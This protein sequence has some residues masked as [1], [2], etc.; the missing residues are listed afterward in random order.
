MQI[1]ALIRK[2]KYNP[3]LCKNLKIYNIT[4][5][6]RALQHSAFLVNL[7]NQGTVAISRWVSAKR[8]RSYPYARVYDTLAHTPRITIIPV[9][10]DEGIDGE[11]DYLQYDTVAMMS[12]LNV[13]V[14]IAY[15]D[16]AV[17]SNKMIGKQKISNQKVNL[18]FLREKILEK[19]NFQSDPLH[20]NLSQLEEVGK[21][22]EKAIQA[23]ERISR[24]TGVT[25]HSFGAAK[26]RIEEISKSTEDFKSISRKN[27]TMAANR[28]ILTS[29]LAES[30]T[31]NKPTIT[32]TNYVGG[33]YHL[34]V[35]EVHIDEKKN[36][37]NL[38]EAKNTTSP[39]KLITSESDIKDA[40]FK[41]IIFTN[42]EEVRVD[43]DL[44][45]HKSSVKF[46]SDKG[47]LFDKLSE[48]GKVEYK[49]LMNEAKINN[50]SI[51]HS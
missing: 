49:K 40:I 37:I 19:M 47:F 2:L 7:P 32:I 31:G 13:N 5:L 36:L 3:T 45:Q 22:G 6:E 15:Y 8:T 12:L 41:M 44:Y 42:L 1:T 16:Y 51:I 26:K 4:D 43:G 11:R 46:T 33:E 28:E 38:V 30:T 23:Y 34:T 25:M 20:W 39:N 29:H 27:A 10:K 9:Y 48:K 35:D 17:K 18:D 14:I 24:K 50:F 21:I